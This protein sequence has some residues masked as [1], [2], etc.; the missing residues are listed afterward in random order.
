MQIPKDDYNTLLSELV[1]E[2]KLGEIEQDEVTSAMLAEHTNITQRRACDILKEKERRGELVSR[3]V[4]SPNG[5][6]M[7]AYRK[8]G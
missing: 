4:R 2:C 1:A 8:V 6:R 3:W 5:K 7:K